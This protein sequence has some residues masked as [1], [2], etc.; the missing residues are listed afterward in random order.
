MSNFDEKMS[1]FDEKVSA[2][3]EKVSDPAEKRNGT[4]LTAKQQKVLEFC[5]ET[6]RSAREIIGM[7]GVKYHTKTLEQYVNKLV[8]AGLLRPTNA[9]FHDSNRK[10][11]TAH[12]ERDDAS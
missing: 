7:V 1:N 8:C 5:D 9:K 6:P 12:D 11:I 2:P 10:Y 4:H 3:D